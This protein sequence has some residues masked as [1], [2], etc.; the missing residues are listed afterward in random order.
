MK[1]RAIIFALGLLT[2]LCLPAQATNVNHGLSFKSRVHRCF[3]QKTGNCPDGAF[4]PGPVRTHTF[5]AGRISRMARTDPPR[6]M[7]GMEY[8]EGDRV[9]HL[10][11]VYRCKSYPASNLC[12]A[13]PASYEPGTGWKWERAWVEI[14]ETATHTQN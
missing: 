6:Y 7:A 1:I 13:A 11:R 12:G 5:V 2:L 8:K 4:I 3:L 9:L 14:I 10:G